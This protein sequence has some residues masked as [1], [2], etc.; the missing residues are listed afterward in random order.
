MLD[1]SPSF[2][3][4]ALPGAHSGRALEEQEAWRAHA[5]FMN[6]LV[7]EGSRRWNTRHATLLTAAAVLIF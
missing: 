1:L 3:P 6:A 5:D 2:A 4:A 7:D